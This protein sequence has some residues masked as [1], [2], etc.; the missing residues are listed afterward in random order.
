M[1]SRRDS[2]DGSVGQALGVV[3]LFAALVGLSIWAVSSDAFEEDESPSSTE[4]EP[5]ERGPQ[6]A[7]GSEQRRRAIEAAESTEPGD[8]LRE[9]SDRLLGELTADLPPAPARAGARKPAKENY[10]DLLWPDPP[11]R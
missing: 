9:S 7:P 1:A 5:R 3:V 6:V 4:A 8:L 2:G 11:S 10:D